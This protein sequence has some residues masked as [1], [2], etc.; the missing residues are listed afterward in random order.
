MR[1]HSPVIKVNYLFKNVLFLCSQSTTAETEKDFIRGKFPKDFIW[2]AATAAYQIE[3]AWNEDGKGPSVWD[4]FCHVGGKIHNNDT[5][6]VACDS[7]HKTEEDVSLLKDLGVGYYRFSISW[8]RVLPQGTIDKVNP[9]GV[10]YYNKLID[11]LLANGIKPAVT[12]Y[13]FDLP[14]ALQD[15]G[16]W[17]NP[18]ISDIFNEYA[19]FCFKEFGDRVGIWLTINEPH[20]E[21]LDAY[22]LGAFAPGLKNMATGP[23]LGMCDLWVINSMCNENIHTHHPTEGIFLWNPIPSPLL[24]LQ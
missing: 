17:H 10:N 18:T 24:Y 1:N 22:G 3:G 16:G 19:Q 7:Y 9:L 12:L 15:I 21:A 11:T 8:S 20:E 13:H 14:Q 6:D 23:Y 2:G 5:G 4:T